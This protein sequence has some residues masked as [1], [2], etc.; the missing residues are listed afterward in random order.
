[1]DLYLTGRDEVVNYRKLGLILILTAQLS[2][3]SLQLEAKRASTIRRL[4]LSLRNCEHL[5]L[6]IKDSIFEDSLELVYNILRVSYLPQA[7]NQRN[8]YIILSVLLALVLENHKQSFSPS[9]A[10]LTRGVKN[11]DWDT[12]SASYVTNYA[13]VFEYGQTHSE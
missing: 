6:G 5:C 8:G 12:M 11:D 7:S 10:E 1:M 3:T 9:D 13:N 4:I 2:A